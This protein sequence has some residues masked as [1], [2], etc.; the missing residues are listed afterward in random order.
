MSSAC[1]V[2]LCLGTLSVPPHPPSSKGTSQKLRPPL[3]WL[4][5]G[6]GRCAGHAHGVL[7]WQWLQ[8]VDLLS[9]LH[10]CWAA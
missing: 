8:T 7:Q 5:L 9:L 1:E 3:S 6:A 2:L 4:A 10:L